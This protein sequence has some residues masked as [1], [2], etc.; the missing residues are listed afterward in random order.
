MERNGRWGDERTNFYDGRE[1]DERRD[2]E[3]GRERGMKRSGGEGWE[4]WG[5][6]SP[7]LSLPIYWN[8]SPALHFHRLLSL[9]LCILFPFFFPFPLQSLL[10]LPQ[11]ISWA[12]AI[13]GLIGL[14]DT[15]LNLSFLLVSPDDSFLSLKKS[16]LKYCSPTLSLPK[17]NQR[18]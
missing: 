4:S 10:L 1:E 11:Y 3:R 5:K 14:Y 13:F 12:A 15:F 6:K 9:S 18:M 7:F 17:E 2:E 8:R 16:C